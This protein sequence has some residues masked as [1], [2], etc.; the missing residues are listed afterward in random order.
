MDEIPTGDFDAKSIAEH[1]K[2]SSPHAASNYATS[3]YYLLG[4]IFSDLSRQMKSS[5]IEA[6]ANAVISAL[7]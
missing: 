2:A 3:W 6:A 4:R 1:D 7:S 5:I